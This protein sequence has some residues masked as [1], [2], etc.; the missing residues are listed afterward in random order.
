MSLPYLET[1]IEVLFW[2]SKTKI[3]EVLISKIYVVIK[4]KHLIWFKH[5]SEPDSQFFIPKIPLNII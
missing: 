1:Q 5:N 2:S 4:R 3:K